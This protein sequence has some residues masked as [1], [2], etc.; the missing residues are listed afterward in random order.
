MQA[1]IKLS[2]GV[3]SEPIIMKADPLRLRQ[4]VDNVLSNAVKFTEAGGMVTITLALLES[5]DIRL[6][7]S[8]TGIAEED[9]P[10]V[11]MAFQEAES[12][13]ARKHIGT[14]LGA[15][16]AKS[17]IELHG[18]RVCLDSRVVGHGTTV[19]IDLPGD[20]CLPSVYKMIA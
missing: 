6:K 17:L 15:P 3:T 13:L 16:M 14:G 5:G 10:R 1:G 20:R 8:D 12:H 2:I 11:F 9:I 19:T 18:G 4:V 7:I